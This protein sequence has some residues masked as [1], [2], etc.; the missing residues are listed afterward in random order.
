MNDYT[1][2]IKA[3]EDLGCSVQLSV[4]LSQHT[5]FRIGGPADVY[6]TVTNSSQLAHVLKLTGEQDI[7]CMIIGNGSNLLVSDAGI[8]G[9]VVRLAGDFCDVDY[10]GDGLLRA[11]AGASL[12]NFCLNALEH[13]LTGLE[14]AWGIPGSVGGAAFMNAGA[15]GGEMK[16]V[17]TEVQ[18]VTSDGRSEKLTND[19]CG[20]TYR[21]SIFQNSDCVITAVTVKLEKGDPAKIKEYMDDILGRRKAKQPLDM[22]SAGSVFK[23]PVGYFAGGLIEQ[24][25]LKGYSVGG[26]QVSE[27]HAGFIVNK[28]GATCKD[29]LDLIEHIQKTV[30]EQTGVTLECEVRAIGG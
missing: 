14:F 15:Y 16:D 10:L 28:G 20:F 1:S 24:C 3:L 21:G 13:G 22:P 17:V 27:K 7:P 18:Y 29:V 5:S 2:V 9:V 6:V 30:L 23:R 19:Q 26:A 11:G 25:C 4:P 8:R 12:S